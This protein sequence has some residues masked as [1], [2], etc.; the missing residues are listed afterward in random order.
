MS[1][2]SRNLFS[3]GILQI[4]VETNDQDE[5]DSEGDD[6]EDQKT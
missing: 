5:G 4:D 2:P 3:D 6:T 1:N